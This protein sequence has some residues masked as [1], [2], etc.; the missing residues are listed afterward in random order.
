MNIPILTE[1]LIDAFL[2]VFVRISAMIMM[3]PVFGDS[4]VPMAIRWGLSLLLTMILFPLVRAGLPPLGDMQLLSLVI[5]MGGELLIG[6]I[7]GFTAR[8][9]FAGVQFAGE[10]LGFQMGFSVA[11]VIDPVSNMQVSTIAEVQYLLC[12]LLFLTVNAHHIFIAAIAESYQL[13]TPLSVHVSGDL[14][15]VLIRFSKDMFIIAVKISAPVMAV[16]FFTNLAM[17]VVSRTVPQLNV[18]MISFPLQ[19]AVGFIFIGLTAPVFVKLLQG[20]FLN[21]PGE[22]SLVMRLL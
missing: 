12:M 9:M 1:E 14:L 11:N 4:I 21:L 16:L 2:L 5:G 18:F 17:G 20:F 19:I 15:Q 3:I 10:M 13:V 22:I 7:I 6:I 8:F